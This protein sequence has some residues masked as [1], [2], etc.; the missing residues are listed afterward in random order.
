[1]NGKISAFIIVAV[2]L[3]FSLCQREVKDTLNVAFL[4]NNYSESSVETC[5]DTVSEADTLAMLSK[6]Y[7]QGKGLIKLNFLF[8][9]NLKICKFSQLSTK[10]HREVLH[11]C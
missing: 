3:S 5:E 4:Q 10:L 7:P 6:Q 8:L 1:M 2:L 11:R 9:T